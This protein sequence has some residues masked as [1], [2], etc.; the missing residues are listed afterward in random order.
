MSDN[1]IDRNEYDM[2]YPSEKEFKTWVQN[3]ELNRVRAE[4]KRRL[5]ASLNEHTRKYAKE[6]FSPFNTINS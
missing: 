2:L 5:I 6:D 3:Q 4:L 1:K